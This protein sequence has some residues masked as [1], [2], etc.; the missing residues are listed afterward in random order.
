MLQSVL[1]Q[2]TPDTDPWWRRPRALRA[3]AYALLTRGD[4][5]A[6]AALHDGEGPRPFTVAALEARDRVALRVTALDE[7][8][9]RALVVGLASLDGSRPLQFGDAC[10]A[11]LACALHDDASPLAGGATYADLAR[12]PFCPRVALVFATP[13]AFSQGGDR[14]LPLPVPEL[15][16]RSW[17]ARWNQFAPAGLEIPREDLA[18][19]AEGVGLARAQVETQ[20]VELDAATASTRSA[21]KQV[22]FTGTVELEA[23]RPGGWDQEERAV[24]AALVEYSR[25]CGTGVRTTQG[26]GLTLPGAGDR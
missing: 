25:Y 10:L 17:A 5:E 20:V 1:V 6:A 19:V 23:L 2:I 24:F 9:S 21:A 3:M 12:A 7:P 13:T 15:M 16:L 11:P 14:H 22:G 4:P 8:T 18:R 26:L